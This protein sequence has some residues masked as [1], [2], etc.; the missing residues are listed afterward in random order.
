MNVTGERDA[1]IP[2]SILLLGGLVR[3]FVE[4]TGISISRLSKNYLPTQ[5]EVTPSNP[6]ESEDHK[7]TKAE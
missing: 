6:Q 1:K 2:E 4:E 3:V 5:M 7:K